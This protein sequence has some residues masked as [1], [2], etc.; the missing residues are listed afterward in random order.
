MS[1]QWYKVKLYLEFHNLEYQTRSIKIR[2]Q[3]LNA[4][5]LFF[6][7]S[8]LFVRGWNIYKQRINY[9][10]SFIYSQFIHPPISPT[11]LF[12]YLISMQTFFHIEKFG[13]DYFDASG[14]CCILKWCMFYVF[15]L[16]RVN[17]ISL[18]DVH[19]S[20]HFSS[21][22]APLVIFLFTFC[23]NNITVFLYI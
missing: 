1:L 7:I 9:T 13:V 11:P 19:S 18:H 8:M 15:S 10:I 22:I 2:T 6:S 4:L 21:M 5:F 17:I 12:E 3:H 14:I 16:I 23:I 20:S